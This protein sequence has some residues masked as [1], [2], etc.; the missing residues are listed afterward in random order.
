MS[1]VS[2]CLYVWCF[3]EEEVNDAVSK[4][5]TCFNEMVLDT[6]DALQDSGADPRRIVN[7]I[8]LPDARFSNT[9]NRAFFDSLRVAADILDLFA[10]LGGYWDHFNYYLLEQLILTRP[11]ERLFAKGFKQEY[12]N[13]RERMIQYKEDMDYFRRHTSVEV[14]SR[15]VIQPKQLI[16]EGFKEMIEKRDDLKTLHDVEQFRQEVA[17][18]YRLFECLVFLKY[19]EPG[20]VIV[21]LWIPASAE[22]IGALREVFHAEDDD[23]GSSVDPPQFTREPQVGELIQCI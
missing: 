3:V 14:Y 23:Q 21:T 6:Q 16:P 4:L 13:L 18:E 8:R 5:N 2:H 20:S 19:M 15:A 10:E 7:I 11:A 1:T 12:S 9:P 17:H 22:P